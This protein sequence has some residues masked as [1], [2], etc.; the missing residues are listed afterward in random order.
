M[1][2][3]VQRPSSTA[4]GQPTMGPVSWFERIN[5]LYANTL[6]GFPPADLLRWMLGEPGSQPTTAS[7]LPMATALPVGDLTA[8]LKASGEALQ[9]G[10]RAEQAFQGIKAFH[11]S[12]HDFDKFSMAKIGTGEGAQAYGHGL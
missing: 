5:D 8:A 6:K 3:L 4:T 2:P 10:Q 1:P 9:A 12:P 7:I 11:G